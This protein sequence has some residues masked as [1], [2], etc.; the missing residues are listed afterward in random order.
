[1]IDIHDTT[2]PLDDGTVQLVR[3]KMYAFIFPNVPANEAETEVFE[4]AVQYQYFHD[5]TIAQKSS[6]QIP[7]GVSSFSIGNF[8]MSFEKDWLEKRLTQK[9]ICPSAYGLLLRNGLLYRGV[10]GR[11]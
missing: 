5:M 4:Q 7:E 10:E 2:I 6:D 8:S 1:M 3:E 11:L 9:T